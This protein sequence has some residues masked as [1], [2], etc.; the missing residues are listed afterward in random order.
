MMAPEEK[1]LQFIL[2]GTRKQETKI[3]KN[4]SK[5]CC[6]ISLKNI[7]VNQLVALEEKLEDHQS[8]SVLFS[9]EHVCTRLY[10]RSF[11]NCEIFQSVF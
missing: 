1:L 5:Y 3:L 7:N 6:D 2:R 11:S 9:G 10:S 8:Q 4:P